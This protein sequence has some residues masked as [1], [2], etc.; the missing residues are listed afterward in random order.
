ML[1]IC[2]RYHDFFFINTPLKNTTYLY[3]IQ[4]KTLVDK[5]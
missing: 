5:L 3:E 4:G 1:R 2:F